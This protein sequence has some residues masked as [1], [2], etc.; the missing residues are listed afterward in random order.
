M[1]ET[2][3]TPAAPGAAQ[4][5]APEAPAPRRLATYGEPKRQL[6]MLA[7]AAGSTLVIDA[8]IAGRDRRLVAHLPADEEETSVQA[9]VT[10]Y[11]ADEERGA[12]RLTAAD[13]IRPPAEQ[14]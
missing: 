10:E 11:L 5:D 1:L 6:V 2:S 14:E 3:P 13:L 7:G 12:R 8:T 9:V 4:Q